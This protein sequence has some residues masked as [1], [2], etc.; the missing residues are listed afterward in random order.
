MVGDVTQNNYFWRIFSKHIKLDAAN[1]GV[2]EF[3]GG[4]LVKM[5]NVHYTIK[6]VQVKVSL[7]LNQ[8]PRHESVLEEW[9]YSSTHSLTAALGEG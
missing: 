9:R 1:S 5:C 3:S 4:N 7:C 8:A 2:G 6:K